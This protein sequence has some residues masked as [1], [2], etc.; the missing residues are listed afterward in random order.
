MRLEPQHSCETRLVPSPAPTAG[1]E[2]QQ[3]KRQEQTEAICILLAEHSF[4]TQMGIECILPAAFEIAMIFCLNFP[5][6]HM[7]SQHKD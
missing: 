7:E 3:D 4:D 1:E 2:R 6:E 5:A